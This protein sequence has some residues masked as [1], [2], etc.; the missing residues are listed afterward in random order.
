MKRLGAEGLN[1]ETRWN[2]HVVAVEQGLWLDPK[3]KDF[4]ANA[5]YFQ[6]DL[7]EAK[8]LLAAAGYASGIKDVPPARWPAT[9][10]RAPSTPR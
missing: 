10:C 4:G 8:K 1:V 5:K 3:G 7:T 2:S 9:S 6:H